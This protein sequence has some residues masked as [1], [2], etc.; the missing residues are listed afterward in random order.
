M[1]QLK[2]PKQPDRTANDHTPE[3]LAAAAHNWK[4]AKGSWCKCK[5]Q[6]DLA[7]YRDPKTGSHGWMCCKCLCV[8]QIG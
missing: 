8:V 7:Y 4:L 1:K 6:T 2:Q 3:A 5:N